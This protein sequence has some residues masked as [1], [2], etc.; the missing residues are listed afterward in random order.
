MTG[1]AGSQPDQPP[2]PT[3]EAASFRKP[4]NC[5]EQR[6]GSDA[7]VANWT[8]PTR[9][10]SLPTA[11]RRHGAPRGGAR[12]CGSGWR[13]KMRKH[14]GLRPV[15]LLTSARNLCYSGVRARAPTPPARS[16]PPYAQVPAARGLPST[17]RLPAGNQFPGLSDPRR[18]CPSNN[19]IA[20]LSANWELVQSSCVTSVSGVTGPDLVSVGRTSVRV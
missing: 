4:K 5:I 2:G 19:G 11:P 20:R 10:R 13:R 3:V 12:S 1:V 6:R 17:I 16:L 7:V 18:S 9:A 8:T 14:F 15:R